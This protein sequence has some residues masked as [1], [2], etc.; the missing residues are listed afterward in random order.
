MNIN[1][2]NLFVTGI[3]GVLIAWIFPNPLIYVPLAIINGVVC[4]IFIPI[5]DN[6]EGL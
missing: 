6:D 5:F 4:S 1:I 2:R 3:L